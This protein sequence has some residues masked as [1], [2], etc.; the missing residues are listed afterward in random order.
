MDTEL[1]LDV[2]QTNELKL[3]FRRAGWSNAEIKKL[4]EGNLLADLL[5]LVR[6]YGKTPAVA[7]AQNL[8]DCDADP[9]V[10]SGLTAHSHTKGGQYAFDAKQVDL[11][12]S[13]T[14]KRGKVIEGYKL[15]KEVATKSPL[16]ANVLDYLL[17]NPCC[18]SIPLHH[19]VRKYV[20]AIHH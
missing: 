9:F 8:I 14:Q 20:H 1:M 13:E 11:Y 7:V 18:G 17:E 19:P 3:A 12:L 16:N 4:S 15:L 10:P 2:G 6:A 5:P